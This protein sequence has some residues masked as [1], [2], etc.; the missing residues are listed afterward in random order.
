MGAH[1]AAP[2][3]ADQKGKWE[4]AG[5]T[6]IRIQVRPT[7]SSLRSLEAPECPGAG[8]A[9]WEQVDFQSSGSKALLPPCAPTRS[10]SAGSN[11]EGC[12]L[13]PLG[14]EPPSLSQGRQSGKAKLEVPWKVTQHLPKTAT[15]SLGDLKVCRGTRGLMARFLNR[16]KRNLALPG[17]ETIRHGPQGQ[18]QLQRLG[19]ERSSPEAIHLQSCEDLSSTSSLRRLLSARRLERRRP[20]SLSG[21]VRESNL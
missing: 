9:E 18:K 12:L 2:T 4:R 6:V 17:A 20:H 7:C 1:L 15:R 13:H 21:L 16:S 3:P 14:R 10:S 19:A 5:R 8:A 11:L